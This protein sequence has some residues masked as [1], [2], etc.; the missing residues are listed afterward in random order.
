MRRDETRRNCRH[1]RA[2]AAGPGVAVSRHLAEHATLEEVQ[3]L[4]DGWLREEVTYCEG[5]AMGP[6]R[7]DPVVRRRLGQKLA[8]I[9]N[10]AAPAPP[11]PARFRPDSMP[12]QTN[13]LARR[14]TRCSRST[15]IRH[16]AATQ[17]GGQRRRVASRTRHGKA[18]TGEL[19]DAAGRTDRCNGM[20]VRR[21]F[22]EA[23]VDTV[24]TVS[25]GS[26]W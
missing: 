25:V 18:M 12:T 21:D 7:D 6:E 9:T 24:Q 11:P 3:G 22:G 20:R 1:A 5:L 10:G 23:F 17:G 8:F 14:G 4:V 16:F 2:A 19:D 15:A 26:T 13:T